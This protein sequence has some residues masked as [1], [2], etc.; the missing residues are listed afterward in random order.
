MATFRELE[1]EHRAVIQRLS[2]MKPAF[3]KLLVGQV[4]EAIPELWKWEEFVEKA[5][6][7]LFELEEMTI[8]PMLEKGPSEHRRLAL[9]LQKEHTYLLGCFSRYKTSLQHI[10]ETSRLSK[11][12]QLWQEM[13]EMLMEHANKEDSLIIP[14][15]R[16]FFGLAEDE[17]IPEHAPTLLY[18]EDL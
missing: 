3:S 8:I 14:L 11:F 7:P 5:L 12:S 10:D 18:Q 4:I 6:K 9:E 17:P 13:S 2:Q 1:N 16:K 15:L